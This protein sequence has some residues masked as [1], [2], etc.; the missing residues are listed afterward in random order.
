MGDRQHFIPHEGAES[1][2]GGGGRGGGGGGGVVFMPHSVY[3]KIVALKMTNGDAWDLPTHGVQWPWYCTANPCDSSGVHVH[4]AVTLNL[5]FPILLSELI[6]RRGGP[7][8]CGHAAGDVV[9]YTLSD[10]QTVAADGEVMTGEIL[11]HSLIPRHDLPIYASAG[12]ACAHYARLIWLE[13]DEPD[14]I[15]GYE[16]GWVIE[17]PTAAYLRGAKATGETP[18]V[19]YGNVFGHQHPLISSGKILAHGTDYD[20]YDS[21]TNLESQPENRYLPWYIAIRFIKWEGF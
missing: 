6:K 16:T 2:A 17:T 14:A 11:W 10:R 9:A 3:A 4:A 5:Q 7:G 1:G 21:Q 19:G 18:G 15:L 13:D 20:W 8:V 12:G